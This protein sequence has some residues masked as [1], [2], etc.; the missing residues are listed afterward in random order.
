L[1]HDCETRLAAPSAGCH[2]GR[3]QCNPGRV[4]VMQD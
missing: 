3:D 2:P 1:I 4:F